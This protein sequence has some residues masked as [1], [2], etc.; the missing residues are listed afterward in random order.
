VGRG[1]KLGD[2]GLEGLE[3]RGH[4]F[5]DEVDLPRQH[6]AF[7]HQRLRT[8]EIFEGFE[9]GI[10][11]AGE[12]DHGEDGHFV[13]ETLFVE[14]RTITLD[15]AGLLERAHAPEAGRSGN[16]DPAGELNVG[17]AAVILQLSKN[18]P[19]DG[20]ETSGH[21]GLRS[22][23]WRYALLTGFALSTKHYCA[24]R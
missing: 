19:V 23:S 1:G 8:H 20:V 10:G 14:Q 5:E 22:S 13:A 3:V 7:A 16:A 18:L 12:V 2:E 21:G 15:V 4:A 11:L 9:V 24:N 6:P 17:H